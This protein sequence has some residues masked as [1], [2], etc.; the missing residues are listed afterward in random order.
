MSQGRRPGGLTAL[1]VFNFIGGGVYAL[2]FLVMALV[3]AFLGAAADAASEDP[4]V[5]EMAKM[6]EEVGVGWFYLFLAYYAAT[7]F[8]LIASGVGYIKQN[9][10]WGRTLGTVYGVLAIVGVLAYAVMAPEEADGG[11]G[12]RAVVELIY[13]VLTVALLNTTFKED[14]VR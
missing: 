8:L 1:A 11:F 2:F 9:R 4:D 7:A 10:F 12:L 5:Q 13:P 3:A 14:F 6:W